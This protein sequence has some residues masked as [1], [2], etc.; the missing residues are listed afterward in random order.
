M[1]SIDQSRFP[2]WFFKFLF[3]PVG[4]FFFRF[5]LFRAGQKKRK[6]RKKEDRL[7]HNILGPCRG[8]MRFLF[9]PV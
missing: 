3:R 6:K 2:F 9:A 8:L 4:Y 7:T 1:L 5:D